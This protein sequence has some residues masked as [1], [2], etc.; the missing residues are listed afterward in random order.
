M[1]KARSP[2]YPSIDLSAALALA[3]KVYAKDHR[4]KVSQ[5]AIA[6]H[7][8]H[9]NLSGPA[10]GKI[11]ALR[12]YG[13]IEGSGDELKITD[14]AVT[15][16]MAPEGAAERK[17]ALSRLSFRP[18]L[19]KEARA[20]FPGPVSEEN[21]RYW[22]VKRSFI[23]DAA[24]KAAKT[25]LA[26][27]ALVG[28][29]TGDY[30]SSVSEADSPPDDARP[31]DAVTPRQPRTVKIMDGER[32]VFTEEAQP[33]QYVKLVA[34]GDIDA[35]LLD[36]IEDFVKRQRRRLKPPAPATSSAEL[37]DAPRSILPAQK[38]RLQARPSPPAGYE[39]WS[40]SHA[41]AWLKMFDSN[42]A[43]Q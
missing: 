10:L 27:I 5:G 35:V 1:A 16:L 14:D 7:L 32:V 18:P 26:T 11:G 8:G 22:L 12:A 36:A 2:N 15:A 31:S 43:A 29:S 33:E 3:R 37:S 21:L 40:S 4:N 25:Y 42:Q 13:L 24:A 19:F 20:Q 41:D 17:E 23:P 28:D 39:D 30:D 34:S 38:Q 6:K 9:E